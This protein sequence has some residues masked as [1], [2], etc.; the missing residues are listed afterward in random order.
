MTCK[1]TSKEHLSRVNK[2][3]GEN[4]KEADNKDMK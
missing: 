4:W 3:L 1:L 2:G